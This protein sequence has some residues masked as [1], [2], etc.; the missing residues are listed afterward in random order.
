L[1]SLSTLFSSIRSKLRVGIAFLTF[2]DLAFL[3]RLLRRLGR[4]LALFRL[5]GGFLL[6]V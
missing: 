3:K 5:G 2:R 6:L 1:H 4:R